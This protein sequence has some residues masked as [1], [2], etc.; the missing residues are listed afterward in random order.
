MYH[1]ILAAYNKYRVL[2]M[3]RKRFRMEEILL[4]IKIHR[5]ILGVAFVGRQLYYYM[6][7]GSITDFFAARSSKV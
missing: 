1:E 5:E 3:A 4:C 6:Y 2:Y 7:T